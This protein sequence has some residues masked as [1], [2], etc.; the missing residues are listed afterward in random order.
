MKLTSM[1]PSLWTLAFWLFCDGLI[2]APSLEDDEHIIAQAGGLQTTLRD[3][4]LRNTGKT[5]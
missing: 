1:T 5:R 3:Y 4:D 2:G